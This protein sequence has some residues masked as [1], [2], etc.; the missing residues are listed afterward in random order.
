VKD[1]ARHLARR[2]AMRTMRTLPG[3]VVQQMV[4][5]WAPLA[6]YGGASK[7][8]A[9]ALSRAIALLAEPPLSL[10][11][12]DRP[13]SLGEIAQRLGRS[14]EEVERWARTGLLGDPE[15]PASGGTTSLWGAAAIERA[16]LVDYLRHH[17]V[18]DEE[19]SEANQ[20]R[21]LPLLVIDRALAGRATMTLEEVARRTGV[22]KEFA[23]R[24][25]RALGM[26]PGEPGEVVYTRRDL[27]AMRVMAAMRTIFPDE[28]LVEATSVLGLA[29]AQVAASHVELF[30]RRIGVQMRDSRTG[31]LDFVLRSAAMVDLMLPTVGH[32]IE[33]AHRRHIEA[34]VRGESVA[35]VEEA[36]G[37]L[38][39]QAELCVGFAD[40]VG[41]TATSERV[42]PLEL[43]E[44]AGALV[45][46][47]EEALPRHGARIVKTLGD[48][49]MFSAPEPAAAA[50]AALDLL[51]LAGRDERLP[52][53]RVGLAHGPVLRRYGD[54][55][56]RTVNVASRL[57]A[58]AAPGSVL[59]HSD[60]PLD[61]A[62]WRERGV[63]PG[64]AQRVKAKGIDGG[65]EAVPVVR[66]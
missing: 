46:H 28:D 44:M 16:R 39:G 3:P 9:K 18:S 32:L 52:P 49:V 2:A 38:P 51:E 63:A 48:A 36:E 29:M 56:G 4:S 15:Q 41:F 21:R 26:P 64:R 25:W 55:F 37:S 7:G 20:Q 22:E 23:A 8:G 54:V 13:L 57:C 59:L 65:I 17:D 58:A 60:A 10:R 12:R 30:R 53:L 6:R 43:G 19:L 24:V 40:L 34:A 42:E 31:N 50:A 11:A 14:E 61:E 5:L 35:A 27:E 62:A 45:H 47:A 33:Q 1:Q 66:S